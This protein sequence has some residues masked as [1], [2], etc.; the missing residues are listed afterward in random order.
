[1]SSAQELLNSKVQR[2]SVRLA[3]LQARQAMQE[4]RQQAKQRERARR[5]DIA[6]RLALGDAVIQAGLGEWTPDEIAGLLTRAKDK[7]GCSD[8]TRRILGGH[9]VD[10]SGSPGPGSVH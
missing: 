7:F 9:A 5:Q 3:Q 1:M 2:A 8:V 10:A 4:L 6:R